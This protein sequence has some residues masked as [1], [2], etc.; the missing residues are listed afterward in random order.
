MTSYAESKT[1]PSKDDQNFESGLLPMQGVINHILSS[2]ISLNVNGD[3]I[4]RNFDILTTISST[5]NKNF[6]SNI[7]DMLLSTYY[8]DAT[9]I[10]SI[11][12]KEELREKS[13][14]PL[15]KN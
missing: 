3:V 12:F 11:K 1:T 10:D 15:Q 14:I 5:L 2:N 8:S 7:V 13:E 4:D 9:D 6:S